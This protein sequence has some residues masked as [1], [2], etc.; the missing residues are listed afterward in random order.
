MQNRKYVEYCNTSHT[1]VIV[2]F[3]TT[4][5]FPHVEIR[6][7]L[8]AAMDALGN[9]FDIKEFHNIVIGSGSLLLEILE[10]LVDR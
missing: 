1:L 6:I 5:T 2:I 10:Q 3:I 7:R 4:Y 9:Q 8:S